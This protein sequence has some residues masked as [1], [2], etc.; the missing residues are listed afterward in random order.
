MARRRREKL[1][2]RTLLKGFALKIA[3]AA[4]GNFLGFGGPFHV[5]KCIFLKDFEHFRDQ[6]LKK[7]PPAAVINFPLFFKPGRVAKN[8]P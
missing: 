8:T 4:G 7:F 6:N 2:F 1:H 3:R 5:P